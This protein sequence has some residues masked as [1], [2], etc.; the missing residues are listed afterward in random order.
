MEGD[1]GGVRRLRSQALPESIHIGALTVAYTNPATTPNPNKTVRP[2]LG[3]STSN[4][5]MSAK[6]RPCPDDPHSLTL[7]LR[8]SLH[9]TTW[10]RRFIQRN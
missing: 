6:D 3:L 9:M 4:L 5:I 7:G 8:A 2:M 1:R 10:I